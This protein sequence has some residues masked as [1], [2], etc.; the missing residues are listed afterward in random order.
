M[1]NLLIAVAFEFAGAGE[2]LAK[3]RDNPWLIA[4]ATAR[5]RGVPLMHRT[6]SRRYSRAPTA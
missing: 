4:Q 6:G 2:P 1:R 3:D 5:C